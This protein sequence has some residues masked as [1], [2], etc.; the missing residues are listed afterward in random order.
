[1]GLSASALKIIKETVRA[2]TPGPWR[3]GDWR[4][5]FGTEERPDLL[6][7]RTL[8]RHPSAGDCVPIVRRR[9]EPGVV[10]ILTVSDPMESFDDAVFIMR[11]RTYID[12]L[13]DEVERLQAEN[14]ALKM[15]LE[16][17]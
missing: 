15:L 17:K 3:W 8:E 10:Q 16:A 5:E 13:V 14:K 1:M 2:A 12:V 9:D 11:S 6:D 7:R 4:A